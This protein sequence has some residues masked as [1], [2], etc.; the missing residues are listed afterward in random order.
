VQN[1]SLTIDGVLIVDA[2]KDGLDDRR[3]MQH[4]DSLSQGPK[5][6]PDLDGYSNM[7]EQIMG[8]DPMV[9][10]NV[11]LLLDLSRWSPTLARPELGGQ[12][13]VRLPGLGRN[14][15]ARA[16]PAHEFARPISGD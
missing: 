3:E 11:P 12:P 7:R 5:D 2:D 13:Q 1:V 9:N 8:T 6:D 10:N 14:R 15:F 16:Q 4:F